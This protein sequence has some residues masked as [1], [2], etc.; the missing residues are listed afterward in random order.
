MLTLRVQISA[1]LLGTIVEDATLL[2]SPTGYQACPRRA[3]VLL[4]GLPPVGIV[5]GHY[6]Q[7]ITTLEGQ[8]RLLAGDIGVHI[9]IVV[10]VG[11]YS[12]LGLALG[13]RG[14]RGHQL[15]GYSALGVLLEG[16][17]GEFLKR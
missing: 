10:K 1:I 3:L 12:H 9:G 5:L 15:E 11:A 7:D 13:A 16:K 14:V 4:A 2:Q 8:T 17:K 6:M